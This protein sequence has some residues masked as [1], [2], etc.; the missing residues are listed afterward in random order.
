MPTVGDKLD[1]LKE[2][3][4]E[5]IAALD[6][7]KPQ[8]PSELSDVKSILLQSW[9]EFAFLGPL[10]EVLIR[11][12]NPIGLRLREGSKFLKLAIDRLT[13]IEAITT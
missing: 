7:I 13:K 8:S 1:S 11:E 3:L 2:T 6:A 4:I 9:R 10:A 5:A 12:S